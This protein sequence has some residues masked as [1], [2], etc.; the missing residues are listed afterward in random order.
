[1]RRYL[2]R[3]LVFH[4][5][6]MGNRTG[7]GFVVLKATIFQLICNIIKMQPNEE[8]ISVKENRASP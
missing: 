4:S 8:G 6:Y 2:S 1:M 3:G 5:T 7:T